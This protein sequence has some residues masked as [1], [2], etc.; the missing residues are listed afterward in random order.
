MLFILD[1]SDCVR[2]GCGSKDNGVFMYD[3]EIGES[4]D[5]SGLFDWSFLLGVKLEVLN[6]SVLLSF[7][8]GIVNKLLLL[9]YTY[10]YELKNTSV[11]S[12]KSLIF[13]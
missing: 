7:T 3:F 9:S 8:S 10:H 4:S 6:S 13:K 12:F 5:R 2:K 11:L 1:E